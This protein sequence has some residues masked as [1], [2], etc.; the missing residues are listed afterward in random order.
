[1]FTISIPVIPAAKTVKIGKISVQPGDKVV[2]GQELFTIESNK[3]SNTIR[4]D[5]DGVICEILVKEGDEVPVKFEAVL[6]DEVKVSDNTPAEPAVKAETATV[7][8]PAFPG[9]KMLKVG[10]ILVKAG[11]T[12]SENQELFLAESK[13]GSITVKAVSAG[14]IA[15]ILISEGDEVAVGTEC[16]RIETGVAETAVKV[17]E[18]QPADKL[19]AQVLIIGGGIGGYMAAIRASR[20][21]KKVVLIEKNKM[22]GTCLNVGCIP[23]KTLIASAHQYYNAVH[24]DEFGIRIEGSIQPDMKKI[25]ARKD[26]VV[27]RLV[28]GVEYLMEKNSIQVINGSASFRD[29]KTVLVDGA[30]PYCITFDDCIIATGS[31]VTKPAI[32]GIDGDLIMDSTKALENEELPGSVTIVGGGVIGLEFAFLYRDLGVEVTVIEFLDRLVSVVDADVSEEILRIA[33]EKGIRV[34]LSSKVTAFR[35]TINGTAITEFEKDGTRYAISS[36]RVLVAIGRKPNMEGLGLE[37]TGIKLNQG[38]K[39]IEVDEYMR[40]NVPHIYAVGD[41][42]NRIQLAHAAGYEGMIAADHI[43]GVSRAFD[44]AI[45]PSVIFT[46]PEIASVGMNR[47]EA[48][49]AGIRFH[50][51][52]FHYTGNGKALSMNETEGFIRVLADEEDTIIGAVVIGAD[53]STLIAS[54]G[55][56]VA[57]QLKVEHLENTVFAHPTTAEVI[58]EAA[59]DLAGGAYHE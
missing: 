38:G 11:D 55:I 47:D 21:G 19:S 24:A 32:E 45:I 20:A 54:L 3:G 42:N 1:M 48:G 12:V 31:S 18:N 34:E 37:H 33:R 41:V 57:N 52:V 46:K 10:K 5:R 16:V 39:G 8:M 30:K 40:T 2:K 44:R 53:A 29:E 15:E 6:L 51:G 4:A 50:E 25:I 59:L 17:V 13:K 22:G 43:L 35:E 14:R 23:T 26:A 36:D 49:K 56:C 7:K 28:G 58:H 27:A 9:S